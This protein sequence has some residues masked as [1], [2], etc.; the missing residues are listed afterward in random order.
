[1]A[2]YSGGNRKQRGAN[3]LRQVNDDSMPGV[4]HPGPFYMHIDDMDIVEDQ[5]K[6]TTGLF[7]G[8]IGTLNGTNFVTESTSATQKKYYYNLQYNSSTQLSVT[9][10]HL[11][12]SGSTGTNSSLN[13]GQFSLKGETEAIYRQFASHVMDDDLIKEGFVFDSGSDGTTKLKTDF[14]HAGLTCSIAQADGQRGE[15]GMYFIQAAR[16]RMKDRVNSGTWTIHLSGSNSNAFWSGSR[17]ISTGISSSL[18]G[19]PFKPGESGSSVTSAS[20]LRLTDDSAYTDG[21]A[22]STVAGP[23]Y[24]IVS[25]SAGTR[26]SK[27]P[28]YGWFYPNL[29]LWALR[30][31]MLSSSIPGHP[32]HITGSTDQVLGFASNQATWSR[33]N[34]LAMDTRISGD[35]DNAAKL[36]KALRGSQTIRAEEDQTTTSYFCRAR[37]SQFNASNNHTWLSGSSGRL[38][39]LSMEGNPQTMITTVGLYD[40]GHKLVAVGRIS[41]PISKNFK[42]EA[43]LKVNLTF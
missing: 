15:P 5:S 32:D 31:S 14:S 29:G 8:N 33:A 27:T 6:V 39:N 42:K 7:T 22:T 19:C 3:S 2:T 28:V 23:R 34:G 41:S 17:N 10:G 1:M 24:N 35:V 20:I 26:V 21:G 9:F 12:G 18:A 43:T 13:S 40:S 16:S 38:A 36:V 25:G 11:G 37:A 30:E 4:G